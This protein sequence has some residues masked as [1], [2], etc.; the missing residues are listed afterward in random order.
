MVVLSSGA[1]L[2]KDSNREGAFRFRKGTHCLGAIEFASSLSHNRPSSA[3]QATFGNRGEGA[4]RRGC[5]MPDAGLSLRRWDPISLQLSCARS[6][7]SLVGRKWTHRRST[8]SGSI[9]T[10]SSRHSGAE[11]LALVR[12]QRV[13]P[14]RYMQSWQ[15]P[16]RRPDCVAGHVRFEVRRETGKE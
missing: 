2:A 11:E 7:C 4:R 16:K 5:F 15:T 14:L 3:L 9:G 1:R 10:P 8:S 13:S 12:L 6:L